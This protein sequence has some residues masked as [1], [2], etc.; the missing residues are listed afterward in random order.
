M[1][2]FVFAKDCALLQIYFETVER[3]SVFVENVALRLLRIQ[4]SDRL[5]RI[6]AFCRSF[7]FGVF[8]YNVGGN[9]ISVGA[10]PFP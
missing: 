1:P 9:K 8:D 2:F 10:R 7:K 5:G 3:K 4:K 6:D